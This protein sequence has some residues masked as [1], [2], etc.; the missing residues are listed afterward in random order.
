MSAH[1]H[2]SRLID[3]ET[4]INR[5]TRPHFRI[6]I[7][8]IIKSE[9]KCAKV[10]EDSP[11]A[12]E[13]KQRNSEVFRSVFGSVLGHTCKEEKGHSLQKK[14]RGIAILLVS[15]IGRRTSQIDAETS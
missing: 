8:V 14:T 15:R 9:T 6:G 2:S 3:W 5:A 12:S 10:K 11:I 4:I 13:V 7:S 1:P